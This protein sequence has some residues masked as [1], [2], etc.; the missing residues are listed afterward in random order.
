[1]KHELLNSKGKN[2]FQLE[3]LSDK[4]ML[5]TNWLGSDLTLEEVQKGSLMVLEAIKEHKTSKLLNDNRELTGSWDVANDWIA[6][7]W[8]PQAIE[9]GLTK[10][11][12]VLPEDLFAQFS[13]EFMKDNAVETALQI[14][15]FDSLKDAQ[16]WLSA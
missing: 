4:K 5:Y 7:V 6:A 11:A 16:D 1:M 14:R 10:F 2:Y 3:Y 9:A 8:M 13:A 15:L 12:H